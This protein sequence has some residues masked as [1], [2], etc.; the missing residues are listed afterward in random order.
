MKFFLS[1]EFEITITGYEM[2]R[3]STCQRQYQHNHVEYSSTNAEE[4][5][6][7]LIKELTATGIVKVLDDFLVD[8]DNKPLFQNSMISC[9]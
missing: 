1:Q 4:Q 7:V 3:K 9:M 8:D 6:Q 2:D 5:H